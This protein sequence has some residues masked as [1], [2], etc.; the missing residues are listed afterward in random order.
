MKTKQLELERRES[1]STGSGGML[2]KGLA[3][4]RGSSGPASPSSA[5]ASNAFA[6]SMESMRV[7]TEHIDVLTPKGRSLRVGKGMA[8]K[9]P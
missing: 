6:G 4:M 2:R 1:G 5:G 7:Q 3:M 9:K 8:L